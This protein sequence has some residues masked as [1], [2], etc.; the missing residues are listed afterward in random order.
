MDFSEFAG[1]AQADKLVVM[2]NLGQV[3]MTVQ[4]PLPIALLL[5][6]LNRYANG[7]GVPARGVPVVA[8]Y[9][10]FYRSSTSLGHV[11]LSEDMLVLHYAGG[12]WARSIGM[13]DYQRLAYA[14]ENIR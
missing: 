3:Q 4:D 9:Y 10:Y 5:I 6:E 13:G 8:R 11:G 14:L 7:W 1:F 12:F 2:D